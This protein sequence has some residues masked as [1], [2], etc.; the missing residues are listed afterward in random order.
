LPT[1][2]TLRPHHGPGPM[3]VLALIGIVIGLAIAFAARSAAPVYRAPQPSLLTQ[4]AAPLET[5][6]QAP[7]NDLEDRVE[8]YRARVEGFWTVQHKMA[9][10]RGRSA[11]K[12]STGPRSPIRPGAT[13]L[14]C[15]TQAV[16]YEARGEPREGQVGVAQVVMNR[17]SS[18]RYPASVCAVVFQGA[19]RPGCQFSFACEGNRQGGPVNPASWARSQAVAQEVLASASRSPTAPS[20]ADHFHADYVQPKWSGQMQRLVQIGRH[21]FFNSGQKAPASPPFPPQSQAE[22]SP[23]TPSEPQKPAPEAQN[24]GRR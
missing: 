3:L 7:Q 4:T 11:Q 18:G 9:L 13:P 12:A 6:D 22:N 21:I 23:G 16:Y 8:A 19:G 17:V 10:L 14:E 20:G 15:L 24:T 2:P 1:D 5:S